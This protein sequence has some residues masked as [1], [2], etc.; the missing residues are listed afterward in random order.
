MVCIDKT[1]VCGVR[2]L[3]EKPVVGFDFSGDQAV[4]IDLDPGVNYTYVN[5]LSRILNYSLTDLT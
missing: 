1:G 2:V 4:K 5:Q 3:I